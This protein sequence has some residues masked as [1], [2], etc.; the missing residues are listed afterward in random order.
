M[1]GAG[2]VDRIYTDLAVVDVQPGGLLVRGMVRGLAFEQLQ[3]R[4]GV[5]LRRADDCAVLEP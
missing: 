2:V 5:P 4:T 1:P 3:L